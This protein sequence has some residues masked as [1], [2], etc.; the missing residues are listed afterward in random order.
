MDKIGFFINER[1]ELYNYINDK[2]IPINEKFKLVHAPVKSGKRG[3]VEIYSL[4][5]KSSKHIYLT[6]LHRKADEK[7]RK[8]LSSYGIEVYSVN[9]KDKKDNCIKCIDDLI[10]SKK[11]VKIH[12]DEL[13][14]GCG[15]NQLLSYIWTKYKSNPSVYFILYSA[16]IEVAKKEFLH[17]NNIRD[18]Y[19]CERYIPPTTYFGIKK[20]LE[21]KNFF[22]A[23]PFIIYN[24]TNNACS[25]TT[26]G[27]ELIHK[28]TSNT[29]NTSNKRHIGV[30]RLA[31]NF[32]VNG[33]LVSQF[34]KMKDS[35]D[36]IEDE[37]K[38][39]L[40]F[41]GSNDNTVEWDNIKYW[42]E[43]TPSFPFIIVI[44]QV[45]GRS[46]EWKCHPFIVWYHTLRTDETPIGTIIQDQER[47]VYYTST[48]ID[49]INI[50]IYGDLECAKYSAGQ[51]T[52]QQMLANTSR[53]L[54]ARLDTKT[55][56]NHVDV[57]SESYDKWDLIPKNYKKGKSLSTHIN[58]DNILKPKMS[59]IEKIN[60]L[61]VKN[62][63]EIKNWDKYRHLE[64]FY[65]T[66]IRSSRINF[67]KGGK[68]NNK[69]I[70]FKSDID[71]ELKEGINEKSRIRINLYYEDGETD[72][73]K[74]K[75]IVRKFN[76][77]KQT[78]CSNTTM[79]N[80]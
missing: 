49:D 66:N 45:S 28:L 2:V 27:R 40:K 80:T 33:K 29:N 74:Y 38:V 26:Q 34:E 35:K 14:F 59:I 25:I 3:M 73:S 79:Y 6:A 78:N 44:N 63:Y 77:S 56:K 42:E 68:S 20:Y 1:P 10:G 8:E 18:V 67:I 60:N 54:N 7:Q 70:W 52:L 41:V 31:G 57:I 61:N 16:T 17:A 37:Y 75:F 9:N 30:L 36:K 43:L 65:M 62:E 24:D 53:K 46:T 39:R 19:E 50:E 64:G 69:A 15:N 58:E 72:P 21:K 47:P 51:I 55:K 71:T 48:Y 5:D 23:S 22:K 32:K 76:G 13:D 4:I 11:N 12:L